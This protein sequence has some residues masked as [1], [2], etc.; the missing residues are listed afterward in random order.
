MLV[1]PAFTECN[2]VVTDGGVTD[3]GRVVDMQG[4]RPCFYDEM[5]LERTQTAPNRHHK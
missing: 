5:K 4:P 2:G 3:G 1:C